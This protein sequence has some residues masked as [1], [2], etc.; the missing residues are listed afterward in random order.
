MRKG[1]KVVILFLNCSLSLVAN[2]IYIVRGKVINLRVP[3]DLKGN[4]D[5]S[6]EYGS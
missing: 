4:K 2:T 5:L 1:S 6:T 3:L